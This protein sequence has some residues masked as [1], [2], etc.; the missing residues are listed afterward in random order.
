MGHGPIDVCDFNHGGYMYKIHMEAGMKAVAII[1][2][3]IMV[4]G[5][6]IVALYN[7]HHTLF[8]IPHLIIFS[9]RLKPNFPTLRQFSF[10]LMT[11]DGGYIASYSDCL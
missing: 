9:Y 4:I 2:V 3:F 5:Q 1:D 6:K 7:I 8:S 11:E 10:N